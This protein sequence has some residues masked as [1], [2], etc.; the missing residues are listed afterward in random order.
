MS[1]VFYKV[2]FN[3]VSFIKKLNKSEFKKK[4]V[5]VDLRYLIL[6]DIWLILYLLINRE[7]V[8]KITILD[9]LLYLGT[10]SS[11]NVRKKILYGD[12]EV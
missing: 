8:T 4:L 6:L 11:I 1:K 10:H 7:L 9:F 5:V 12:T 3:Q 2:I